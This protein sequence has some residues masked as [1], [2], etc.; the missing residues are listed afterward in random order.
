VSTASAATPAAPDPAAARPTPAGG[1]P[2]RSERAAGT[3]LEELADLQARF[4]RTLGDPTRIRILRLLSEAPAGECGVGELVAAINAPQSRVSTHLGCLRWC[5]LVRTRR[6]GKQVFYRV[7]DPRVD[8]L[9][10]LGNVVM[11]DHAAEVA[12]CDVIG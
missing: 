7:A 12:S 4:F 11:R 5:G 6:E 9:L 1:G 8:E 10:A 3:S 2:D